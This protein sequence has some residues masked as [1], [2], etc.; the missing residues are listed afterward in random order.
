MIVTLYFNIAAVIDVLDVYVEHTVCI[1]H[2]HIRKRQERRERE[3][4][5]EVT[6]R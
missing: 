3:S 6:I 4:N 2:I 5:N 1:H